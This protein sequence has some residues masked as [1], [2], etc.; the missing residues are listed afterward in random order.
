MIRDEVRQLR[1]KA[2]AMGATLFD[3]TPNKDE[4]TKIATE[5][6]DLVMEGKDMAK[7][8]QNDRASAISSA[9][10]GGISDALDATVKYSDEV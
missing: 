1:E 9:M 6:F 7:V 10:L 8:P 4:W 3:E 5:F 2:A